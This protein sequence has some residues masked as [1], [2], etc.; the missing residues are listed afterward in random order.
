MPLSMVF[1][2]VL[3]ILL[4]TAQGIFLENHL[5][6]LPTSGHPIYLAA[7]DGNRTKNIQVLRLTLEKTR[8]GPVLRS[9]RIM[10]KAHELPAYK[11]GDL[12]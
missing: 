3:G 11:N 2:Y 1:Q 5:E 4:V 12:S 10:Y 8:F 7:L 6:Y 9:R